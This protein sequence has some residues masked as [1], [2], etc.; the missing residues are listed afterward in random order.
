MKLISRLYSP[1]EGNMLIDGLDIAK[2]ELT[3]LRNQIGI[4]PQE[5]LLF[6]G[7]I[8]DNIDCKD[9]ATEEEIIKASKLA[10]AHDFIME[11]P[12]GYS[13]LIS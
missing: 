3:S 6:N 8:R 7:T 12:N 13:T 2:V 9:K 5:S 1:N 4:V 10:C 11:L